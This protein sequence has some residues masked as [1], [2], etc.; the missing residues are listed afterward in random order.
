MDG[1][2]T[3]VTTP[4]ARG[5]L[6]ASLQRLVDWGNERWLGRLVLDGMSA[7]RRIELFDR[8][9]TI[10][11][12][13]F[14]SI[15]PILI[16][17]ASWF[18][19][20]STDVVT[21]V[22]AVPAETKTTIE[23]TLAAPGDAT[24]G[25]LGVLVVLLSATSLSRALTRACAAV[26]EL[27]RPVA[28][29][30]AVWRW[31]A[32][33]LALALSLVAARQLQHLSERLP[34]HG[35][36]DSMS[37]VAA[38]IAVALFIPMVLLAGAVPLRWLLPGAALFGLLMA[39]VRPAARAYLPRVLDSSAERYGSIGVAFTYLTFLYVVAFCFLAAAVVGQVIATD[40]GRLGVWIRGEQRAAAST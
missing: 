34:P 39:F 27:P 23:E 22:V 30:S 20:N 33:V 3:A 37:A 26:W 12:Q 18:G 19:R 25:V 28:G 31:V 15:L 35:F 13:I 11:A 10:A 40:K 2:E 7:V 21:N 36:W 4:G 17:L 24:F 38:D 16:A 1:A 5:R 6:P 14:T 29:L 32:V 9:M 8:S